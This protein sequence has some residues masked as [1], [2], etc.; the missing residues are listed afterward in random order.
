[1]QCAYTNKSGDYGKEKVSGKL[2]RKTAYFT[3]SEICL[4]SSLLLAE[5]ARVMLIKKKMYMTVWSTE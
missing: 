1:M 2:K 4:P 5:G 3:K